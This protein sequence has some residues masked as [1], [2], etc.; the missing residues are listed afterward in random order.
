[1]ELIYASIKFNVIGLLF[2]VS[3]SWLYTRIFVQPELFSKEE[4]AKIYRIFQLIILLGQKLYLPQLSVK[5]YF[6]AKRTDNTYN[7]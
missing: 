1:M 6:E 4:T 2:L 5:K 7:N 3:E